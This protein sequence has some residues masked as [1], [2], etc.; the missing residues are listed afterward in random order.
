MRKK[1]SRARLDRLLARF[2]RI[3]EQQK[4]ERERQRMME[5]VALLTPNERCAR[6]RVLTGRLMQSA[7]IEPMIGETYADAAVRVLTAAFPQFQ[8]LNRTVRDAL[9]DDDDSSLRT[10]PEADQKSD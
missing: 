7:H 3:D 2:E 9:A 8:F 5:K 4:V 1:L 10:G 6:I